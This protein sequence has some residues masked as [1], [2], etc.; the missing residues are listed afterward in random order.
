MLSVAFP[1]LVSVT[2]FEA[3]LPTLT[4][5]NATE[6]GLIVSCGCVADVP[7]PVR[8]IAICAGEPFVVSAID[9][10][11]ELPEVGV[12]TALKFNV[13]PAAIVLDVDSPETLKPD[14]LTPTC[15][16]DRVAF[17]LFFNVITFE[18]LFPTTT[19]PKATL[20]GLTEPRPS[21]PV[22]LSAMV[23]GDPG[24]LLEIEMLPAALPSDVG[25]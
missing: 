10:L 15:E 7:V 12:N 5:L 11:D 1:L 20:V 4:L 25:A 17:P 9:P 3:L 6:E 22:P 8:G 23:A 14:P 13:A 19:L 21:N 18:L 16:K 2:V 24:A